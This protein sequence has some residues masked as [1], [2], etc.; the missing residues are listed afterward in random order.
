MSELNVTWVQEYDE[1]LSG[2]DGDGLGEGEVAFEGEEWCWEDGEACLQFLL[3]PFDE[4]VGNP[5]QEK[6]QPPWRR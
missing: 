1:D 4:L 3:Q 6:S 5:R 2:V